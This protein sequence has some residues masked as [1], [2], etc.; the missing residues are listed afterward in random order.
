MLAIDPA[1][2]HRQAIKRHPQHQSYDT[3]RVQHPQLNVV[4]IGK[5]AYSGNGHR[6]GAVVSMAQPWVLANLAQRVHPDSRTVRD[7]ALSD[8]F[9]VKNRDAQQSQRRQPQRNQPATSIADDQQPDQR[10]RKTN[11]GCP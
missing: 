10:P 2:I 8:R 1:E 5:L 7:T 11:Q 3:A 6:H 4:G 9:R